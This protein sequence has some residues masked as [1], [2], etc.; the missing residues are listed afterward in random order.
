MFL[1]TFSIM[2]LKTFLR[3]KYIT[4][5]GLFLIKKEKKKKKKID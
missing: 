1:Q 4:H 3:Y 5:V 2:L